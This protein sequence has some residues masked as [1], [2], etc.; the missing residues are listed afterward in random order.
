M[1]SPDDL[2]ERTAN[3]VLAPEDL[4]QTLSSIQT[5]LSIYADGDADD[6]DYDGEG[7]VVFEDEDEEAIRR[8]AQYLRLPL[9]TLGDAQSTALRDS[10]PSSVTIGLRLRPWQG[11][12]DQHERP[13]KRRGQALVLNISY[14]I[15]RDGLARRGN[16]EYNAWP[17]WK[18]QSTPWLLD[19]QMAGLREAGQK[20]ADQYRNR[21]AEAS[22]NED[23]HGAIYTS[24]VLLVAE[25]IT[26]AAL[27]V[28]K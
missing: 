27:S 7:D 26:E 2:K 14:P 1:I 21:P 22:G 24:Y 18:I 4:A 10:L 28:E 19:E 16:E 5:V 8:V 9:A 3:G 11:A 20:S 25:A 15:R 17:T 12:L 13:S 6:E 23:D